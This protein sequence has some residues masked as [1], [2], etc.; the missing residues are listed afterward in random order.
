MLDRRCIR[1]AA[2]VVF[3]VLLTTG[4]AAP[5]RAVGVDGAAAVVVL[6][7]VIH[8]PLRSS[9]VTLTNPG[10][11]EVQVGGFFAG[12]EGGP[13]AFSAR[14]A[15]DCPVRSL[16]PESTIT[17]H[18]ATLCPMPLF[19]D[20]V[21]GYV[22]LSTTDPA[23]GGVFLATTAVRN[24]RWMSFSVPGVPYGALDPGARLGWKTLEVGGL[25]TSPPPAGGGVAPDSLDCY[26]V[27][28]DGGVTTRGD[29]VLYGADGLPV[30]EMVMNV[31]ARQ[32][33]A[34]RNLPALMG[35]PAEARDGLRVELASPNR[36]MLAA[37]CGL[38]V[39]ET[40]MFA[41]QLAQTA[42]TEDATRLHSTV[43]YAHNAVGSFDIGIGLPQGKKLVFSTYLRW[44]DHL[45]C[46]LVPSP[47]PGHGTPSPDW[48]ELRVVG[49]TGAVIAGGDAAKDTFRFSPGRRT[50][51]RTD[52]GQRHFLEIS[53][54]ESAQ[55]P[56]PIDV[57]AW[58]IRCDSAAGMS[59][60]IIYSAFPDDF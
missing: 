12:A 54:D 34:Y 45:R 8:A 29:L 22:R 51:A 13:L 40:Q 19:G 23:N 59:E 39:A 30:G 27:N 43:V 21:I 41:Y 9:F 20:E 11:A 32:M 24:D 17:L 48:L 56:S 2:G 33:I 44:E 16:P 15:V 3:G 49:P 42:Q 1:A 52:L 4:A 53:F 14:K 46:F 55:P 47:L 5:A 60:P 50:R 18:L 36:T 28:L 6:P 57:L 25:R 37:G 58:A 7:W 26:V 35:L 31:P 38:H 10:S